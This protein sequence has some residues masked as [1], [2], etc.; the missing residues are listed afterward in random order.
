MLLEAIGKYM[1]HLLIITEVVTMPSYT[2][3]LQY[4]WMKKNIIG[5]AYMKHL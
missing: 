3:G 1:R 2:K 5:L 4:Q